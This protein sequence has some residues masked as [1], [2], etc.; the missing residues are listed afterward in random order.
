MRRSVF[1]L[2]LLLAPGL[3]SASGMGVLVRLDAGD[4]VMEPPIKAVFT[5]DGERHEVLLSDDGVG[6]DVSAGDGMWVGSGFCDSHS[7]GITLITPAGTYEG[8]SVEWPPS[9]PTRDIDLLLEEGRLVV[10]T[11][12][13]SKSG[14]SEEPPKQDAPTARQGPPSSPDANGSESF[15]PALYIVAGVGMLGLMVLVLWRSRNRA[16]PDESALLP[17]TV[18]VVPEPGLSGP[19]TP[20]LSDGLVVWR[21]AENNLGKAVSDVLTALARFHQVL[22]VAPSKV[23]VPEVAGGPV[24]VCQSSRPASIHARMA[25]LARLPGRPPA[26]LLVGQSADADGFRD[27]ADAVPFNHGGIALV[28]K[29]V[30]RELPTLR[31]APELVA[32]S[33]ASDTA[34]VGGQ[35]LIKVVSALALQGPVLVAAPASVEVPSVRGHRVYRTRTLQVAHV[36]DATHTV[37]E[38]AGEPIHLVV[39]G[40]TDL[41]DQLRPAV[42]ELVTV[43]HAQR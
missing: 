6:A 40:H 9:Q 27:I 23:A 10:S 19:G 1:L 38:S 12:A 32:P 30:A 18:E 42:P 35:P 13:I 36:V 5:L 22:I 7:F 28:H 33:P 15:S 14:G 11:N 26:L 37:V 39:V 34:T 17:R 31:R 24:H 4:Q 21:V 43:V 29:P 16:A 41:V 25:E 20:S 2:P 3:S 8:G